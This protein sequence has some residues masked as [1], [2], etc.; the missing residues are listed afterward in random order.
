MQD[1][2]LY[3]H[4]CCI[5]KARGDDNKDISGMRER[6]DIDGFYRAY[7]LY[8]VIRCK[9]EY[10]ALL[11]VNVLSFKTKPPC[12]GGLTYFISPYVQCF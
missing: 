4:L 9:G 1:E 10:G 3:G 12:E 5:L 11:T 2:E 8:G 6:L 7:V